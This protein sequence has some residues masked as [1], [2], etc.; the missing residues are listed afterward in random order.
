MILELFGK[1]RNEFEDH[2]EYDCYFDQLTSLFKPTGEVESYCNVLNNYA[3]YK[4]ENGYE[5][6]DMESKLKTAPLSSLRV[7]RKNEIKSSQIILKGFSPKT[8]HDF[9]GKVLKKLETYGTKPVKHVQFVEA[10]KNFNVKKNL[11]SYVKTIK[12]FLD[13]MLKTHANLWKKLSELLMNVIHKIRRNKSELTGYA[14]PENTI[15]EVIAVDFLQKA[16]EW[17]SSYYEI[18]GDFVLIDIEMNDLY[19]KEVAWSL[20]LMM[21]KPTIIEP[22]ID[23]DVESTCLIDQFRSD[24]EYFKNRLHKN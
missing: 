1:I 23:P 16:K 2:L 14:I 6:F 12:T 11:P 19:H 9:I 7:E 10:Y 15:G 5:Y 18:L 8:F 17:Q 21:E 20:F 3:V 22:Q 13:L 4:P 24:L